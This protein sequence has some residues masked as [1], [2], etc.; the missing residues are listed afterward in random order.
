MLSM[1][2]LLTY[3]TLVLAAYVPD[4][5]APVLKRSESLSKA[6][7]QTPLPLPWG[8]LWLTCPIPTAS[9]AYTALCAVVL[10]F[11]CDAHTPGKPLFALFWG[12]YTPVG[13]PLPESRC[14]QLNYDE[15]PSELTVDDSQE[16]LV[17]SG[18]P[19]AR[20]GSHL[21]VVPRHY[22]RKY[23]AELQLDVTISCPLGYW[24]T[25][26]ALRNARLKTDRGRFT[27]TGMAPLVPL[28]CLGVNPDLSSIAV[29]IFRNLRAADAEF[30]MLLWVHDHRSKSEGSPR[31]MLR[32][33][34]PP[35][36]FP[37]GQ[38]ETRFGWA[39]RAFKRNRF[40]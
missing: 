36:I 25:S 31:I 21:K 26:H 15:K 30:Q 24:R 17:A 9:H 40:G 18:K 19:S 10:F 3:E 11:L 28:D 13:R 27:E 23:Y 16:L 32:T 22:T 34:V 20:F 7:Q 6:L 29:S 12:L 14:I 39:K 2:V 8:P 4:V 38:Y 33:D 35:R 5:A 1:N 37:R